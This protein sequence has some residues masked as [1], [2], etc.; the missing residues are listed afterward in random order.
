MSGTVTITPL[1]GIPEVRPGD[2]LTDVVDSGLRSSGVTLADGDVVV[3]SSKVA[4]KALGLVTDDPDK[5]RVVAGESDGV[6]AERISG[7]RLTRIVTAKAG[8]VMAAAGVDGSNTG[9]RGGL[10]LLPHDPDGVCRTLHTSLTLRH[11]VRLGVVLSD[12]AGRPWRVGQVDFALGAHGVRVLDDLRGAVDADGRDLSVTARALVDEIAAAADLV[13]G[14]VLGVPVAVVRGLADVV[15]D[16]ASDGGLNGG[17]DGARGL[18]RTGPD[19]WFALGRVEAVRAALGVAPGTAL[20]ARVGIPPAGPDTRTGAVARAV[21]LALAADD[22]AT[23]DVGDES[24]TLGADGPYA[25]GRL[26]ARLEAALSCDGLEGRPL[27]PAADGCSVV[28][29]VRAAGLLSRP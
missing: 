24:V 14:K 13:K 11:G 12:T 28:V 7:E 25:L 3:V 1:H 29:Q 22:E 4:S 23:A 18:V 9:E 20:A 15:L 21:R 2:D 5:E 16:D 17:L 6:V 8:P 26:V 27:A 10:L 19:D